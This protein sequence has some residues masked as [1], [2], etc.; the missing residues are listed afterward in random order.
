MNPIKK[1]RSIPFLV[2]QYQAYIKSNK[3]LID[4]LTNDEGKNIWENNFHLIDH[5]WLIK[6]KESISFNSLEKKNLEGSDENISKFIENNS[7][8]NEIEYLNN[9]T[10]YYDIKNKLLINPM[11]PFDLISDEAWKLFDSDNKNSKYNGRVSILEG[12]K[13]ILIKFDDNNYSVKYNY[14]SEFIIVFNPPENENKKEILEDVAKRDINKWMEEVDFKIQLTQFTINKYKT[15]FDIKQK[16]NDYYYE[17]QFNIEEAI[18]NISFSLFSFSF[19]ESLNNNSFISSGNEFISL[20]TI[21]IENLRY[22]RKDKDKKTSNI[23]AVMRSFSFIEPFVNYFMSP[24]KYIKIFSKFQ[25]YSLLNLLRDYFFNLYSNKK[26][27]YEPK[28]LINEIEK[29]NILNLNEEN[30][31]IIFLKYILDY[32]NKRLKNYDNEIE[33]NFNNVKD[34]IKKESYYSQFNKIIEKNN[35]MTCDCFFGLMLETY[36]C[37]ICKKKNMQNIR[38]FKLIDLDLVSIYD[39]FNNKDDSMV[40]ID[41]NDFL[42][43][44][45]LKKN[46]CTCG[47]KSNDNPKEYEYCNKCKKIINS[48]LIYGKCHKCVNKVKIIKKEILEYPHYL[49]IRLKIGEFVE[50]KGFVNLIDTN[51]EVNYDRINKIKNFYSNKNKRYDNIDNYE[52]NLISMV[53]YSNIKGEVVFISFCKNPLDNQKSWISF[54]CDSKPKIIQNYENDIATPYILFYKFQEKAKK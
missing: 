43:Y 32:T 40:Q 5:D 47:N 51:V 7:N 23:F 33:I 15:P 49:I 48:P 44:Y 50:K 46:Y 17:S 13:K 11:N 37:D 2:E 16:S 53:E 52:Y 27:P 34:S 26:E 38:R 9:K 4:M 24:I 35:S 36:D 1:Q 42:E 39:H 10:I 30:D 28:S 20:N 22:V 54:I 41:I 25:S 14:F 19:S 12:N 45:F 3:K 21:D 6:W 18:K 8:P 31:P 29:K